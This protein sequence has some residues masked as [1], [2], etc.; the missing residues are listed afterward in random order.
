MQGWRAAAMLGRV[1]LMGATE[2]EV[3]MAAD[4]WVVETLGAG[5]TVAARMAEGCPAVEM[6]VGAK[7]GQVTVAEERL[8]AGFGVEGN[9]EE[10]AAVAKWGAA[11]PVQGWRAVAMWGQVMP[12]GVIREEVMMAADCWVVETLGAATQVA[13]MPV[14]AGMRLVAAAASEQ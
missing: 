8:A 13:G 14:A 7:R 11:T 5:R 3:M 1:T 10:T 9:P 6:W 2:E 12:V 4:C